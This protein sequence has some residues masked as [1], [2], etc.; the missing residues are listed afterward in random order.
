MFAFHHILSIMFFLSF[1]LIFCILHFVYHVY[2]ICMISFLGQKRNQATEGKG[3]EME[4][5]KPQGL[6]IHASFIFSELTEL[7]ISFGKQSSCCLSVCT[8]T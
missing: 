7:Y 2:F 8:K 5:L 6:L 3:V 4:P 1:I